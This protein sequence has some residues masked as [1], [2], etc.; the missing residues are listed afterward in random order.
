M[1]FG[2]EMD[3]DYVT[4]WVRVRV[5]MF[6]SS[7]CHRSKLPLEQN[8]MQPKLR[9]SCIKY[10]CI[11]LYSQLNSS[12]AIPEEMQFT[13]IMFELAPQKEMYGVCTSVRISLYCV[14]VCCVCVCV[15]VC[16]SVLCV[17]VAVV[18]LRGGGGGGGGGG[19]S[20]GSGG[21]GSGGS[22]V[23]GYVVVTFI[24]RR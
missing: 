3:R 23:I 2:S 8:A 13:V 4:F 22:V 5:I 17:V 21:G 18:L 6:N 12:S 7:V 16:V 19:G 9:Y 10:S 24:R 1:G 11:K 15:C 20:G 14:C